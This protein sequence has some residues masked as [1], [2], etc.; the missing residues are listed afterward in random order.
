MGVD[1]VRQIQAGGVYFDVEGNSPE[2]IYKKVTEMMPLPDSVSAGAVYDALCV[3]EKIMSTAVGNGIALPH[4]RAPLIRDE[5]DSRICVA[6]LKTPLDMSAP[7]DRKVF[8]MFIL[9]THNP[10]THLEV[11]SSLA[12]LFRN[13]DFRRLLEARAG[14]PEILDAVRKLLHL[15]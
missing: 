3:R 7:D 11:L 10:Q 1:I 4:A 2:E 15:R 13:A 5:K 6:Y 8:V 12:E 9:L 14:E